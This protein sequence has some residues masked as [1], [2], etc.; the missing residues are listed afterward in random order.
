ML[1]LSNTVPQA[2]NVTEH[3][4]RDIADDSI[5]DQTL[6]AI[7]HRPPY[8]HLS[9]NSSLPIPLGPPF[10]PGSTFNADQS[11]TYRILPI[12]A[13]LLIPFS[14]LLS[15]PSLTNHWDVQT[16]GIIVT[17]SRPT[18]LLLNIAMGLSMTCGLLANFF[19]VLRFAE[20][21]VK[22]MTLLCITLL[23]MNGSCLLRDFNFY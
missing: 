9:R 15:I 13:G 4:Q 5:T 21:R 12:I 11:E 8:V 17:K 10:T 22:R 23:S 3:V 16:N 19:L 20:R 14:V 1:V 6:D 7:P 2:P 18:P